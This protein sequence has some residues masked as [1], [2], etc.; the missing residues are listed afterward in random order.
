MRWRAP[1]EGCRLALGGS[2][3]VTGS[4]EEPA[5]GVDHEH[6]GWRQ[7][8][9]WS[10]LLRDLALSRPQVLRGDIVLAAGR[11]SGSAA[12]ICVIATMAVA[13]AAARRRVDGRLPRGH[14]ETWETGGETRFGDP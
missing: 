6:G 8:T 10:L 5:P 11:A 12:A 3:E 14:G 4:N 2:V 9:A 7:G 1:P 13:G